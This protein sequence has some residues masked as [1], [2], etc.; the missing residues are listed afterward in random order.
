[1]VEVELDDQLT[2]ITDESYPTVCAFILGSPFVQDKIHM[3]QLTLTFLRAAGYRPRNSFL[4]ARCLT[5]IIGKLGFAFNISIARYPLLNP[6]TYLF[7]RWLIKFGMIDPVRVFKAFTNALLHL[8]DGDYDPP[9]AII[10]WFAPEIVANM[11]LKA[12]TISIKDEY[13]D[14]VDSWMSPLYAV[15]NWA[16]SNNK[17]DEYKDALLNT[18]TIVHP[19]NPLAA[20]IEMD[21]QNALSVL[22]GAAHFDVNQIIHGSATACLTRDASLIEYA[23]ALGSVECFKYLFSNSNP[24]TFSPPPSLTNQIAVVSFQAHRLFW[25]PKALVGRL[26]QILPPVWDY[27]TTPMRASERV[28]EGEWVLTMNDEDRGRWAQ[29]RVDSKVP[30]L[31]EDSIAYYALFGG[32]PELIQLLVHRRTNFADI[33]RRALVAHHHKVLFW[34]VGQEQERDRP[35]GQFHRT[36]ERLFFEA[37]KLDNVAV[38]AM[39]IDG[40]GYTGFSTDKSCVKL[41]IRHKALSVFTF[42]LQR[43]PWD[44]MDKDDIVGILLSKWKLPYRYL[45]AIVRGT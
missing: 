42:L 38:C 25:I 6:A 27:V 4:L 14:I 12:L 29:I 20:A 1:M 19:L 45:K 18:Y 23:A 22:A 15:L 17:W 13:G 10:L 7:I 36:L 41:A 33:E 16:N 37:C 40:F 11:P 5:D 34:L 32:N 39:L 35:F 8:E 2:A 24:G 3:Y 44:A 28:Y 43:P 31:R 26:R 30:I 21:D 9:F